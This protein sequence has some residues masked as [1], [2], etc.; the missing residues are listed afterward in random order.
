MAEEAPRTNEARSD[1]VRVREAW[2]RPAVRL[3]RWLL[4]AA[5]LVGGLTWG[6]LNLGAPKM[7]LDLGVAAVL[8]AGGLVLLM[9]HR[10]SL[11]RRATTLAVVLVALAGTGAGALATEERVCCM[12]VHVENRGW[13]FD[14]AQRGAVAADPDTAQRLAQS[15]DWSVD[16]LSLGANLLLW[17]YAGMLLMVIA[18]LVRRD[19]GGPRRDNAVRP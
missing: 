10:I 1:N 17:A 16:V 5:T 19:R 18:V 9:P 14:W 15:A 6:L 7:V 11:P 3:L 2:W 8:T 13:P 12:Y 4:G